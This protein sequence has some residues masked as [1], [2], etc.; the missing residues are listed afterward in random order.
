MIYGKGEKK[1][2]LWDKFRKMADDDLH[3]IDLTQEEIT[4]IAEIDYLRSIISYF[5]DGRWNN[6]Y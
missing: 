5:R 4:L 1:I 3:I 2:K 6:E